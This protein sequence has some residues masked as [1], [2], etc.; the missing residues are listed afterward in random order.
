MNIF[1]P[2]C[3]KVILVTGNITQ[4][5]HPSQN[6]YIR[7]VSYNPR[8]TLFLLKVIKYII[9]QIKLSYKLFVIPKEDIDFIFFFL[10]PNLLL[11]MIAA[12]IKRRQT[13][14]IAT[15]STL[16]TIKRIPGV[17]RALAPRISGILERLTFSLTDYFAVQSPSV[18]NFL[19]LRKF[20]KKVVIAGELPVDTE[21]FKISEQLEDRKNLVGYIGRLAPGKGIENFIKAVPLIL[22]KQEEIEFV[23]GGDGPLFGKIKEEVKERGLYN[24]VELVGWIPTKEQLSLLLNRLKLLVLP[25]CSEGVPTIILEA[26]A[27]GTPVL[28]TPVGGVPD[29]IKDRETGYILE[30]NSPESIVA[31]VIR[32]LNC[33]RFGVIA[34]NAHDLIQKEYIYEVVVDRHRKILNDLCQGLNK[35]G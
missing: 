1:R 5:I 16:D 17:N 25:S 22:D 30:N 8:N 14:I 29:V 9:A 20:N 28:L 26:M 13:V 33:P 21:F 35:N 2:L 32:A 34:K 4:K 3:D 19:D 18:V 24:K 12:K 15:G 6:V 7:C 23:I 10:G 31:G 11:P 27:C